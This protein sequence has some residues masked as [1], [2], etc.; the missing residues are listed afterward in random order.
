MTKTLTMIAAFAVFILLAVLAYNHLGKQAQL[1]NNQ[2]LS[3]GGPETSQGGGKERVQAPDFTVYTA[4]GKAVKLSEHFGQP[5]VL[6]FWASWCPPCKGEMPIFAAAY[7][8]N[9]EDITF[10]MI[11]LVDGQRET[12]EKG[13]KYIE[14]NGFTFPV[15]YDIQQDAA[16][17]YGIMSI[18]ITLFLDREGYL[19]TGARGAVNEEMLQ[20][21]IDLIS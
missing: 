3:Q 9:R 8:E 18:P 2:G 11:N 4:D 15:Y 19:V 14:E 20:E 6:N 5:I 16:S 10:M 12:Q 13:A 1:G 17:T 21:G 7:E